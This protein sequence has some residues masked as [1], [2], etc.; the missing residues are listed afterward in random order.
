VSVRSRCKL[1][2]PNESRPVLLRPRQ[3]SKV[4]IRRSGKRAPRVLTVGADLMYEKFMRKAAEAAS[5]VA[6]ETG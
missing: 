1:A 3:V 2:R 6:R 4:A 5:F